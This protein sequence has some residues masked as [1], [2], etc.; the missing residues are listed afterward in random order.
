MTADGLYLEF[1]PEANAIYI[2]LTP[3]AQEPGGVVTTRPLDDRRRVDYDA[4]GTPVGVEFTSVDRGVDLRD[5]PEAARV[6]DLIKTL[7]GVKVL[8][9]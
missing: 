6:A 9:A 7:K 1:D 8:T 2:G 4:S 5:V 3:A